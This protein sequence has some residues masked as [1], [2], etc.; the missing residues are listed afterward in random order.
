MADEIDISKLDGFTLTG[1]D[2]EII[3]TK[4]DG[5]TMVGPAS[6]PPP[7]TPITQGHIFE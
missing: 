2:A 4:L 5:F 7:P 3:V 1:S 6:P